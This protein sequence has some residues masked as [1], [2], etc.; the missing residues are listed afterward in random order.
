[1]R[2]RQIRTLLK[3]KL[4]IINELFRTKKLYRVLNNM[5]DN[6]LKYK[7]NNFE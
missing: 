5:D 7:N 4:T 1:M 2:N 3:S 6:I